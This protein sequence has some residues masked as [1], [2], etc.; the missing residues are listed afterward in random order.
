MKQKKNFQDGIF[1]GM[2]NRI[3]EKERDE[4]AKDTLRIYRWKERGRMRRE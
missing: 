3:W 2:I 1:K 4:W